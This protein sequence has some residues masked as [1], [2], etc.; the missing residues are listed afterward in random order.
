MLRAIICLV[1]VLVP[2]LTYAELIELKC[3]GEKYVYNSDLKPTIN[4]N[5]VQTIVINTK[6]KKL[7]LVI[8]VKSKTVK[9]TDDRNIIR[10]K[11]IPDVFA[12]D[13]KILYEILMLNRY[14]GELIS[15]YQFENKESWNYSFI[16][17]CEPT[18]RKF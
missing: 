15:S 1:A 14:T 4:E 12:L 3:T 11:F 16:G 9:Y 8:G 6:A 7:D 18:K 13:D 5:V 10:V 2:V 17:K